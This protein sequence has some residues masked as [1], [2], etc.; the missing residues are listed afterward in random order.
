MSE[1][2]ISA[3]IGLAGAILGGVISGVLTLMGV[4]KTLKKQYQS[5]FLKSYPRRQK[6]GD[7]V[8][9]EL[10]M[11]YETIKE[12]EEQSN[13]RL[14]H[15]KIRTVYWNKKDELFDKA[16]NV[17]DGCYI[18]TKFFWDIL[19][20]IFTYVGQLISTKSSEDVLIEINIHRTYLT[21][22]IMSLN[23]YVNE[24]S[25]SQDKLFVEYKEIKKIV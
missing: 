10:K 17:S 16:S 24:V 21:Q 25:K 13:Y 20:H 2:M 6:F 8:W 4:N 19:M 15:E 9:L 18:N 23:N 1:T 12:Y 14:L 7:D 3:F 5:E 11:I 22:N